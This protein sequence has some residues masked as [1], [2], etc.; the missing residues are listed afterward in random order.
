MIAIAN[1]KAGVAI[2]TSVIR[3]RMLSTAPR[4]Y[5]AMRPSGTPRMTLTTD[6]LD[7]GQQGDPCGE[8]HPRQHIAAEFV[9]AEQVSRRRIL[10]PV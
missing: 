5:P 9:G 7:G 1:S 3:L 4:R 8:E 2:K 6:A 10:E